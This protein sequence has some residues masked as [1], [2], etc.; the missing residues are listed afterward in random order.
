MSEGRAQTPPRAG[1]LVTGTEV[2][3]G[4]ISDRNGPWLSERLRE[5][6]VDAAMI[7]I[8]GDRPAD[9]V[10]RREAGEDDADQRAPDIERVAEVGREH[11]AGRDLQPEQRR[12]GE[13]DGDNN[14][15]P[16]ED[17]DDD[18]AS[19]SPPPTSPSPTD[20]GGSSPGGSNAWLAG[21]LS[22]SGPGWAAG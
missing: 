22:S 18:P 14:A 13:E 21:Y 17:N 10:A 16:G 6:G 20:P 12:T 7:Q 8:V 19:G 15:A 4:I 1:I 5:V 9:P 11:A 3:T 2:L